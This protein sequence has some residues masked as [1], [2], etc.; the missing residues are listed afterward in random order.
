MMRITGRN[1]RIFIFARL[2]FT[3]GVNM[4]GTLLAWYL[5]EI[6]RDAF[7]L[8]LTGLAEIV[9][10][11]ITLF[12]GGAFADRFR[13][14]RIML[15]SMA[16]F[17]I[18]NLCLYLYAGTNPGIGEVWPI[19]LLISFTGVAR[20][21]LSP[22]QNALLG[23]LAER[24]QLARA[25]T[26]NSAV[27]QSGQ[28]MGPAL[29]GVFYGWLGP[30]VS[31][32]CVALL[33]GIALLFVSALNGIPKPESSGPVESLGTRIQ[34]GIQF[35]SAHKL[36]FPAMLLDM[37]AVLFGGAVAV[38]PLF[39]DQI[40]HTGPEGLGW[41]RAAPAIGS[42]LSSAFLLRFPPE[43]NAGTRMLVA[44]AGFGLCNLLFALSGNF[45]LSLS[46]LFL[47]GIFDSYSMVIRGALLQLCTPD[48]MKGRVS[49]VN[50]I[51][52]GSSNELGAFESGAA[53][54]LMGLVPS[55]IFGSMITFASTG[56]ARL[57]AK[58]L[59][60]LDLSKAQP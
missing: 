57:R 15:F 56:I 22:A 59:V 16:A 5:Y 34:S 38:L 55:V 2:F 10:F 4:Q 27:F 44:V 39:A 50:S 33:I 37:V 29:G 13:R 25:A 48:A 19:Y 51:F 12:P 58:E 54:R 1:F 18:I 43:K 26:W 47:G 17:G 24:S 42:V 60:K 49:A 14:Q 41:L 7:F 32:L 8:G 45:V 40:L 23:Q 35:V 36:L 30:Q 9:P 6:T 46:L 53:A 11:V 28:V 20:G 21:F 31:F 3:L 52:I